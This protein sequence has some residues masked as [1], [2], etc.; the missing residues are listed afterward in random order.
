MPV[1]QRVSPDILGVTVV[2]YSGEEYSAGE[3]DIRFTMQSVSKSIAL[4]LAL[5]D[6][7]KNYVINRVGT[8]VTSEPLNPMTNGGAMV[9]TSMIKGR[10]VEER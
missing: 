4:M 9:V 10:D 5:L 8:E 2:T 1:L 7:G 6:R 3:F